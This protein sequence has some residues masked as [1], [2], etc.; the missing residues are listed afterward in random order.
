MF[1]VN[2]YFDN[3]V[4]SIAF[5]TADLPATLGVMAAGEFEFATD[6][7]EYMTVVS[8]AMTVKLPGAT[9]WQTFNAGETFIVE[10]NLSFNVKTTEQTAYLCKYE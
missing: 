10:A 4:T 8:G 1:K 3:Q 9:E 2:N 6:K 5:Q 7:R